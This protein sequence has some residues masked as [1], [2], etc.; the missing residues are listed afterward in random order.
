MS[1]LPRLYVPGMPQLILQRGN[2]RAGVFADDTDYAQY[3]QHLRESA[4]EAAVAIHAYVLMPNHVHLLVTPTGEGAAGAMMQRLGRRYVRYFNDRHGRSG[5]LW[6]GRYRSTVVDA[7]HYLLPCYNY[8]ELN[9]VRAGFVQ[10]ATHYSWS[11]CRAH[12]GLG[13]DPLITDH[14]LYWA[15]G[16]TP[17][18]RQAA[19]RAQLEGGLAGRQLDAIRF[20]AHHGWM[21]GELPAGPDNVPNRRVQPLPKGRPRR[22]TTP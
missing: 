7:N 18:E 16:N 3:C 17:F 22:V 20:A 11:S 12:V 13:A 14:A 5:T 21:L 10:D 1:R 4:R 8:I 6:E 19:Y 2:N 9:P 15:L